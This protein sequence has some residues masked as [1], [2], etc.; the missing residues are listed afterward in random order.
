MQT[1]PKTV[2]DLIGLWPSSDAFGEDLAL[3][4]GGDHARVMKV[5]GRIPRI[6][7]PLV[8]AGAAKRNLPVTKQ[9]LERVHEPEAERVA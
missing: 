1:D 8:L 6:H 7:W 4:R 2:A 3:K 9:T 5:R